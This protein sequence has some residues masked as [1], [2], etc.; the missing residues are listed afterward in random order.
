MF[1]KR[2]LH[3]FFFDA[4]TAVELLQHDVS[5]DLR[6]ENGMTCFQ[7]LANMPSAFRSGYSMGKLATLLYYCKCNFTK[8]ITYFPDFTRFK[9]LTCA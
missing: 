9:R 4:E 7:L 3:H 5:P 1:E 6:D 2:S 8:Q